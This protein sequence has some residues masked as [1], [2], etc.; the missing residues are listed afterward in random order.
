LRECAQAHDCRIVGGDTVATPGPLALTVTV[1]GFADRPVLR[2]GAR[3]GDALV[4]TGTARRGRRGHRGIG[5]GYTG[6]LVED[7]GA[8]IGDRRRC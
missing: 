1:L 5:A 3:A 4:V 7:C 2:R 8:A 6:P